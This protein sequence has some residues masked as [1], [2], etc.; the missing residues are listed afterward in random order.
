M[1][2]CCHGAGSKMT[3][4]ESTPSPVVQQRIM[5]LYC[6]YEFAWILHTKNSNSG[7][8]L[9]GMA[10]QSMEISNLDFPFLT[11]LGGS[12]KPCSYC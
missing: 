5:A 4:N 10:V 2:V 12:G 6:D 8:T 1:V 11:G 3:T 9:K 7:T